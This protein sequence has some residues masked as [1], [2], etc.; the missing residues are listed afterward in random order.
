[1]K[2][3]KLQS[4]KGIL[5]QKDKNK[6]SKR[7]ISLRYL[8][9]SL[10]KY[11][12]SK[13]RYQNSKVQL[14]NFKIRFN[15]CSIKRC[16]KNRCISNRYSRWNSNTST[17]KIGLSISRMISKILLDNLELV[18]SK[19]QT[20]KQWVRLSPSKRYRQLLGNHSRSRNDV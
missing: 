18:G 6:K 12:I 3:W 4:K 2:G 19:V 10:S 13:W 7:S 9:S 17:N 8:K 14:S 1:M 11:S 5:F 15:K 20:R 16:N